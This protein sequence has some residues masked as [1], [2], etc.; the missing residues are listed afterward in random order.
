MVTPG[1]VL[2]MSRCARGKGRGLTFEQCELFEFFAALLSLKKRRSVAARALGFDALRDAVFQSQVDL[3]GTRRSDVALKR[4]R[5]KS[6][7]CCQGLI[8]SLYL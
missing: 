4:R 3:I 2:C 6:G 5:T 8:T 7:K 1:L